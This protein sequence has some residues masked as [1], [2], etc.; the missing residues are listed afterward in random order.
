MLPFSGLTEQTLEHNPEC[1]VIFDIAVTLESKP[2]KAFILRV[3]IKSSMDIF[4]E[5]FAIVLAHPHLR[6]TGATLTM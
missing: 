4:H 3:K 6:L 5:N 2:S 1:A